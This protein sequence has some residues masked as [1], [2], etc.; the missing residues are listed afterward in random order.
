MPRLNLYSLSMQISRMF[1]QGQSLFCTIKV[2]DWLRQRN[3]D[4]NDY[5]ILFHEKPAPPESG[6]IKMVEIELRRKDG[7]PVDPWLQ[8]EVN[9][10]M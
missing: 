10:Y 4:P 5:D 1:D 2:Q 8:A 6:L 7:Q 9:R 3:Q